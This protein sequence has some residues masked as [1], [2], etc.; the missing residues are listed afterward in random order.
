MIE[1]PFR[2]K[3]AHNFIL[4]V[5]L[6]SSSSVQTFFFFVLSEATVQPRGFW[7]ACKLPVSYYSNNTV[8]FHWPS[9]QASWVEWFRLIILSDPLSGIFSYKK[10]SNQLIVQCPYWCNVSSWDLFSYLIFGT[11]N[12][13]LSWLS[14]S[15]LTLFKGSFYEVTLLHKSYYCDTFWGLWFLKTDTE[16]NRFGVSLENLNRRVFL[17]SFLFGYWFRFVSETPWSWRM[18]FP[19]ELSNW[20]WLKMY[21]NFFRE[22]NELSPNFLYFTAFLLFCSFMCSAV[23]SYILWIVPFR[24]LSFGIISPWLDFVCYSLVLCIPL[25]RFSK[26][27]HVCVVK[28]SVCLLVFADLF[29][30]ASLLRKKSNVRFLQNLWHIF[31]LCLCLYLLLCFL[32]LWFKVAQLG[33]SLVWWPLQCIAHLLN[34]IYNILWYMFTF[35]VGGGWLLVDF[36]ETDIG[37]FI[38]ALVPYYNTYVF[39]FISFVFFKLRCTV[40]LCILFIIYAIFILWP[41]LQPIIIKAIIRSA[42][43]AFVE[44]VPLITRFKYGLFLVKSRLRGLGS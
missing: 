39:A 12:I 9:D 2:R 20:R 10:I 16:F 26:I 42:P 21:C 34:K 36:E 14:F 35:V 22:F 8:F 40:L 41:L 38:C 29:C 33:L 5:T 18:R 11:P 4:G 6:F 7:L 23:Y 3:L 43:W 1:S 19:L 27:L 13:S 37:S 24:D 15:Q 30:G 32:P 31:T 25:A 44:E 17:Q 28:N